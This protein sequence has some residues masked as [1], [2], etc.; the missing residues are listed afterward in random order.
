MTGEVLR[1]LGNTGQE[2]RY[3]SHLSTILSGRPRRTLAK[4]RAK[5]D[6]AQAAEAAVRDGDGAADLRKE[7]FKSQTQTR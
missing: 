1:E 2:T 7:M 4:S 5:A 6:L 3:C